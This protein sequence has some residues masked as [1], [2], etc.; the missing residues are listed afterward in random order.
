M[1]D[2]MMKFEMPAFEET[3]IDLQNSYHSI[4]LFSIIINQMII[5]Q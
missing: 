2:V 3:L 1:K 4:Q 5:N